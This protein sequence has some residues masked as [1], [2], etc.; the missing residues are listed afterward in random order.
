MIIG[1]GLITIDIITLGIISGFD[2]N[3]AIA[4]GYF[5]SVIR[6]RYSIRYFDT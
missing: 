6:I 4:T 5:K 3:G 1:D 2:T